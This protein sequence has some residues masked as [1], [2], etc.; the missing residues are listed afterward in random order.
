M[1]PRLLRVRYAGRCAACSTALPTGSRA[2]WDA[3]AKTL[4]CEPCGADSELLLAQVG[5]SDGEAG[6]SA[7]REFDRRTSRRQDRVRSAHPHLGGLILALSEEP[8]ANAVWARGAEGERRVGAELDGLTASGA[9]VLHDR[10]IP[11]SRA[12]IDHIVVAP[13]GVWVIDAKRYKGVV[14]KREV[15]SWRRRDDRLYVGT[16]D[17][18]RLVAAMGTQV[19]AVSTA[20]GDAHAATPIHP[21]LC[22]VDAEWPFFAKPLTFGDVIVTWPKALVQQIGQEGSLQSEDVA[23][24]AWRLSSAL[25]PA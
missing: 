9:V 21:V 1:A 2:W 13:T 17:C 24:I 11:R 20:L 8:K 7:Q 4:R 18:T 25:K 14:T 6:R 23:K 10:R 15:G 5:S 16:R 12:N 19:A 22:F 3:T